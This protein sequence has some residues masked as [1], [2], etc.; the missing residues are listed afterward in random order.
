ME[1]IVRTGM[2]KSAN[3][4]VDIDV[5]K[6][7]Y[8]K[9]NCP[10]T[11]K[12]IEFL[13]TNGKDLVEIGS[14]SIDLAGV[15]MG[16]FSIENALRLQELHIGSRLNNVSPLQWLTYLSDGLDKVD[17]EQV[18]AFDGVCAEFATASTAVERD[19]VF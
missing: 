6:R 1:C 7:K 18:V 5:L 19:D 11:I 16:P 17:P 12:L 10:G 4:A 3:T 8:A 14:S 13:S 15:T 9:L 2:E